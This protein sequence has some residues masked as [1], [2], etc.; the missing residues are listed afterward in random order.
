MWSLSVRSEELVDLVREAN[1]GLV[2]ELLRVL[3]ATIDNERQWR[4]LRKLVLD[5]A[6][7]NLRQLHDQ[8]QKG[9][10]NG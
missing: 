8:I 5:R 9:F 4:A 2:A 7:E 6:N 10:G 3:E 1:N